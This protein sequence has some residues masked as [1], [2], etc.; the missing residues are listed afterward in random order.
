MGTYTATATGNWS[1]MTWS[2]LGT[3]GSGDTVDCAG[4]TVTIDQDVNLGAGSLVATNASA[5][6][7]SVTAARNI[8]ANVTAT[9]RTVLTDSHTTGTVSITGNLQGGS[10]TNANAVTSGNIGPLAVVGSV[11]GGSGASAQGLYK[12]GST[13][14]VSVTGAVTGGGGAGSSALGVRLLSTSAASI[15]G[16]CVGGGAS[17]CVGFGVEAASTATVNGTATGGTGSSAYGAS[18]SAAGSLTVTEAIGNAF[19]P[20]SAVANSVAGVYGSAT[21]GAVTRV[22][23]ATSGAYGQY[24]VAGA[25]KIV[26][27]ATNKHTW[28]TPAKYNPG[29]TGLEAW[30]SLNETSGN[31]NDS[32]G[33]N[34]L[35]PGGSL[36]YAA[37]KV[38]NAADLEAGTSDYL[39]IADNAALSGGDTNFTIG[40]WI[41]PES[42]PTCR[43]WNKW[44]GGVQEY[45]LYISGTSLVAA[46]SAD[47]TTVNANPTIATGL[48]SG[49]WYFVV[50]YHDASNNLIGWSVN[51]AAY[52]T[53]AYAAGVAD[54]AAAFELGRRADF[55]QYYDG[56]MDEAFFYRLVLTQDNV[57]WLYNAGAGRTYAEV[58]AGP[59]ADIE[60]VP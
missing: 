58:A 24:P 1:T 9:V 6:G 45:T 35:T 54:T 23:K 46:L 59:G 30:W 50:F 51:G 7:F 20:G 31:R 11:T 55:G 3:P 14:T 39:T 43:I 32:H 41:K 15:T 5:G 12:S 8:T 53:N 49:V 40:V 21:A 29:T 22:Y 10:T 33:A 48:S 47:G 18:S 27:D 28:I 16:N 17:G 2:P 37:G 4:Y 38:G 25:V 34:H 19:G 60:L 44:V 36:A 56:L 57:A 26:S 42:L 52:T 13:G